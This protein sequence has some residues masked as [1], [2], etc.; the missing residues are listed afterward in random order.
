MVK[1]QVKTSQRWLEMTRPTEMELSMGE[2]GA[3]MGGNEEINMKW[4]CY[5]QNH[6]E[7]ELLELK[8]SQDIVETKRH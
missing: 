1:P 6:C 7:M 2:N 5:R 8:L 4:S 3:T